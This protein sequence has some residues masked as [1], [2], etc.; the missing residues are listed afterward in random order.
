MSE[1]RVELFSHDQ[2][3][4]IIRYKLFINVINHLQV[5]ENLFVH[6]LKRDYEVQVWQKSLTRL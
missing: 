6:Q 5:K 1:H 2:Q 4:R 3:K